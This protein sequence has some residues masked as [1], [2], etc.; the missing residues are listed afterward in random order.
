[1][2]TSK[3]LKIGTR[4]SPLALAQARETRDRLRAAHADLRADEAIEI[5][6]VKT[7]GDTI[8]DKPLA[9]I[10]GK[11]LFTREIDEAMLDGRIDLAVHSMKD[12]PTWLPDGIDLSCV[13]PREDVRDVFISNKADSLGALPAGAVVGTASL[14]RRALILAKHPRL[15]VETFRGNVQTRLKKLEAGIVDATMLAKAG[16]NRLGLSDVATD[17]IET[18]DLLP[19]VAQGAIGVARRIGDE[20]IQDYLKSLNCRET[21]YRVAAERAFLSV[22]DGSCRTPI[23]ALAEMDDA[24]TMVFKGLCAR[25]DGT[26]II[27]TFRRGPMSDAERIGRDAGEELKALITPDFFVSEH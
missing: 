7:S 9:D 21:G 12:V 22:L 3:P 11:G 14:R 10:G 18:A 8:L 27:E 1:M 15:K 25:P 20:R 26:E 6:V 13:L 19:A 5:V 17:V 24:G 16:L 23:A 2:A 4:G